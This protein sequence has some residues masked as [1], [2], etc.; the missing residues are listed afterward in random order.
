MSWLLAWWFCG[1]PRRRGYDSDSFASSWESFP[2]IWLLFPTP[3]CGLLLCLTVSCFVV[4]GCC[5]VEMEEEYIWR[6]GEV[7]GMQGAGRSGIA[8]GESV[9]RVSYMGEGEWEEK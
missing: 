9:V 3:V 6:R 1:N 4:F 2:Y 8:G 7:E 5:L